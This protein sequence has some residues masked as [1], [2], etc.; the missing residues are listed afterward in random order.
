VLADLEIGRVRCRLNEIARGVD[1]E[2]PMPAALALTADDHL[3]VGGLAA[4]LQGIG[5]LILH[6]AHGL[7]YQ[8]RHP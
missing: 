7:A 6:L 4:R 3:C 5:I 1:L 8:L 2:Q